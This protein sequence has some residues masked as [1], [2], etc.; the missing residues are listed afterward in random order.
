MIPA[1]SRPAA[2]VPAAWPSGPAYGEGEGTA[3]PRPADVGWRQFYADER[4]QKVIVLALENNRNL[5]VSALNIE[6]ARGQYRIQRAQLFPMVNAFGDL[7]RQ[8]VPADLSSTGKSFTGSQYDVGLG[9]TAW[10]IDFFGRLR[11]LKESALEQYLATEQALRSA[12]ISLMAEV[13]I[14]YLSYAADRENLTLAQSTLEAREATFRLVDRRFRLGVS[15]ELD[16]RQ[17]Q[18]A[19]ESARVDVVSYTRLVALGENALNLLVGAPVPKEL[20]PDTLNGVAP[21]ADISAGL[22]S[23]PLLSRPDILQAESLLKS[24][25]ANIGAARAAFFPQVALTTNA[26][27]SSSELSGLFQSGSG[28]WL[29]APQI[30][31]PI[32]D[33]GSRMANLSVAKA[34]RAIAVAS[35][36][37]AIQVAFREVAD[38]LAQRGTL[39]KQIAAQEALVSATAASY[40]L[41]RARYMKGIDSYLAVLDSQRS[42]YVA[43][44]GLIVLNLNRLANIVTLYKVLGGGVQPVS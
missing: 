39:G 4:L 16:L 35:Y 2:P 31:L 27:T 22:S 41:S 40:N 18:T 15:S 20:L 26:G 17:A 42:L 13:A 12:R 8:R 37:K 34:D 28:A 9:F 43:Q 21:P 10:E 6:R 3:A 30:T 25:N 32:F 36:E 24:A 11:S 1:Y 33:A 29:F 5:R 14:T 38:A 19:L 23:E 44:Q 7:Y